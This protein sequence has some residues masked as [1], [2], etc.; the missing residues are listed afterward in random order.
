MLIKR[1]HLL[2]SLAGIGMMPLFT[3]TLAATET[4]SEMILV[5][6]YLGGGNDGLNTVV[7]LPQYA[8][9]A[10]LRTPATPPSGLALAYP[11]DQLQLLAFDA[12]WRT[13]AL[14]AT[15]YA[16][17]P[18]ATAL[19]DLYATGNLAVIAGVGLPRTE[20]NALSHTNAT[21]DWMTGQININVSASQPPGWLG[22][23]LD[24][25]TVGPLGPS[26]SLSGTTPLLIGNKTQGMVMNPP[27]D[28]FGVNYGAS[29]SL[30]S[31]RYYFSKV[32]AL[33]PISST[34]TT[35]QAILQ[36]AMADQTSVHGIA[37][38]ERATNYPLDSWLDYQLRDIARLILGGAGMRGYFAE[39]GGFDTH[40]QQALSHPALLQQFSQALV[41]FYTY[42]SNAGA[43]S[44]VVVATVSDFGRRPQANL[45]F[46]TDH[47]GATVSFVF[48]ERVHGGVYGNY[49]SLRKFDGNGNLMIDIDFRNVISDLMHAMGSAVPSYIG[50]WPRLGFI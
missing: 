3:K 21:M 41:N 18:S 8:D 2:G 33:P 32:A 44:N 9:Y 34:A 35:Q 39:L 28:Y 46:G 13:P 4:S 6:I 36:S 5:V 43:A 37:L 48:G 38:K 19:R 23:A 25:A 24:H 7:P 45:D 15:E 49:P 17:A 16:F 31:L 1:R 20:I 11:Q 50:S 10:K 42:L 27:I 14:S 26:A 47:G 40:G 29:D 22:I 30:A 12:N